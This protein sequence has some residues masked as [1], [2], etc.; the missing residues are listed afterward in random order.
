M[1]KVSALNAMTFH[2]GVLSEH[3]R[4]AP[5]LETTVAKVEIEV[6]P[7]RTAEVR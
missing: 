1:Q 6:T 3:G 2:S 5:Q 4:A 7:A